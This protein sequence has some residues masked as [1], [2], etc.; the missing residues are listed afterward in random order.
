MSILTDRYGM[1]ECD[2]CGKFQSEKLHRIWYC[3]I[4][5]FA[6][7]ACIGMPEDETDGDDYAD[8]ATWRAAR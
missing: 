4:E 8:R 2:C 3:G 1:Y 6:C 7:N 5:T